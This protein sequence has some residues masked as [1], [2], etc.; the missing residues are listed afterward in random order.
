[1][2]GS[3]NSRN[4]IYFFLKG[5]SHIFLEIIFKKS[6][7]GCFWSK[8]YGKYNKRMNIGIFIDGENISSKEYKM[9]L[10]DIRR[11]GTISI[12]NI[13]VD[14]TENRS[15][16]AVSKNYGITPIQCNKINK[17]NSVDLKLAVDIME[18]LYERNI[19]LFCILTTDSDFC[20]VVQKLKSRNKIV[21]IYGYGNI[22]NES[23][24]SV[25]NQFFD[26]KNLGS[27]SE[28][29]SDIEKYWEIIRDCVE[30]KNISN[31]GE[32]KTK[33]IQECPT[34]DVKNYGVKRF[35]VFLKKYYHDKIEFK[36][37]ERITT[38]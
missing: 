24:L 34:F 26:I 38:V 18:T 25:C 21:Y 19:D 32:I 36:G 20:H 11:H 9:I 5:V 23:L 30:E 29:T 8:N 22:V 27:D 7:F 3:T 12:S 17:K 1:M 6:I 35:L 15:W 31:I 28:S 4:L 2:S 33:I 13:Y 16:M 37:T 14:W 10:Q